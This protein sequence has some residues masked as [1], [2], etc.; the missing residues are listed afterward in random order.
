MTA[1]RESQQREYEVW[2]KTTVKSIFDRLMKR[3]LVSRDARWEILWAVPGKVLIGKIW[4]EQRTG[5]AY[6]VIGGEVPED[7]IKLDL[8]GTPRDAARYFAMKW[9]LD[10]ARVSGLAPAREEQTAKTVKWDDIGES[11]SK[12]AE[13]LYAV[14]ERDELWQ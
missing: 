11:L 1:D 14:V 13:Q 10:G 9:Q 4:H 8:A 12:K 3:G 2:A 5:D 7:Y 6:W